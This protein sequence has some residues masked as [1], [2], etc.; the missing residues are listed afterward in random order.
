MLGGEKK[1]TTQENSGTDRTFCNQTSLVLVHFAD[2]DQQYQAN[3]ENSGF[4][5]F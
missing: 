1:D 3:C 2:L 4:F 5:E